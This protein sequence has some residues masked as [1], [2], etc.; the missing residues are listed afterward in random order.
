VTV[1]KGYRLGTKPHQKFGTEWKYVLGKHPDYE[2]V[3]SD[4]MLMAVVEG[5]LKK[6]EAAQVRALA[7]TRYLM[8]AFF[9]G[10]ASS[11][12]VASAKGY[13]KDSSSP[14]ENLDR[15]RGSLPAEEFKL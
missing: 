5:K 6:I 8:L 9:G 12:L 14:Q 3:R 15:I 7:M 4:P 1:N 10:H 11:Q 13:I 2:K